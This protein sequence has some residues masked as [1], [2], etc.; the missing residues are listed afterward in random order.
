L[1]YSSQHY[2]VLNPTTKI[3]EQFGDLQGLQCNFYENLPSYQQFGRSTADLESVAQS[4][5]EE[6]DVSV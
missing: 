4:Y 6:I 1:E 5:N 3:A 2:F